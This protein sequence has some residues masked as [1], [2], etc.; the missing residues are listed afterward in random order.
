LHRNNIRI[1]YN[2]KNNLKTFLSLL[3]FKIKEL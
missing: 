3:L 1:A 2:K